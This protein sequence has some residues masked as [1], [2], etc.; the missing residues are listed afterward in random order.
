MGASSSTNA[1]VPL[2]TQYD[3]S[4]KAHLC[5]ATSFCQCVHSSQKPRILILSECMPGCTSAN[6]DITCATV[7]CT[8]HVQYDGTQCC[9]V[10]ATMTHPF[11]SMGQL[12]HTNYAA[13]HS[14]KAQV[15]CLMSSRL[16][17]VNSLIHAAPQCTSSQ[18]VLKHQSIRKLCYFSSVISQ[19]TDR[20]W[21]LLAI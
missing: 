5:Q 21:K 11:P 7:L 6:N 3:R 19:L 9:R 18:T 20:S 15:T 2:T 14:A 4:E 10:A 16:L 12:S 8:F 17:H 13:V 1:F